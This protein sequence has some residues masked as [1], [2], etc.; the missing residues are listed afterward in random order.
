MKSKQSIVYKW[1]VCI[2]FLAIVGY[3]VFLREKN[4]NSILN[5]ADQNSL[6]YP[7]GT[8]LGEVAKSETKSIITKT[9]DPNV[10]IYISNVLGIKFKYA[11]VDPMYSDAGET[12]YY[13]NIK[14]PP[15]K[16]IITENGNEITMTSGGVVKVFSKDPK[17]WFLNFLIGN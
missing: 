2:L 7:L 11:I 1:L 4:K 16:N 10:N 5:T 13:G 6:R 3:V 8:T 12:D 9:E 14:P 17:M 15:P